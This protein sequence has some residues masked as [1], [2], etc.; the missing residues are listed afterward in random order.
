M[1]SHKTLCGALHG[2]ST[3]LVVEVCSDVFSQLLFLGVVREVKVVGGVNTALAEN[4]INPL[5]ECYNV[6]IGMCS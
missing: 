6:H 5:D 1:Y 3:A 2:S 4:N